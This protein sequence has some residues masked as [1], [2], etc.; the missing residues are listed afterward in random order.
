MNWRTSSKRM[1]SS[2]RRVSSVTRE[3][4]GDAVGRRVADFAAIAFVYVYTLGGGAASMYLGWVLWVPIWTEYIK[5]PEVTAAD[6]ALVQFLAGF[7]D[8]LQFVGP[9][10]TFA[11]FAVVT[12]TALGR[13]EQ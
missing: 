6:P 9:M 10:A 13:L 2:R 7:A 8:A 12:V 11:A 4:L 3:E 1:R 5:Q